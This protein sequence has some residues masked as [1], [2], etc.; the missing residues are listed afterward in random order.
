MAV[1]AA[2]AAADLANLLVVIVTVL[3]GDSSILLVP[4]AAPGKRLGATCKEGQRGA[5]SDIRSSFVCLGSCHG[6]KPV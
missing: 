3:S 6:N 2:T 1:N 5:K 4:D